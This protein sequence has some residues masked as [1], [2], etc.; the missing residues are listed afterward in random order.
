MRAR[1]TQRERDS[2]IMFSPKFVVQLEFTR[3]K[4]RNS[5]QQSEFP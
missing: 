5:G 3:Y 2:M 4:Y 1:E